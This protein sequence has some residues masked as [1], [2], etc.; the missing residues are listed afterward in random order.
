[1]RATSWWP[2]AGRSTAGRASSA[3]SGNF[4]QS[5]TFA[6][7]TGT[8]Q[9]GDGCATT[10]STF[11]GATSFYGFSTATTIGHSLVFPAGQTQ[12]VAHALALAG[13][14]GALVTIRSSS[15][16][17]AGNLALAI[18][19]TQTIDYV[20]VAD[21]HATVQPIGPGPPRPFTR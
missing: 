8:V 7:G 18:G 2:A 17:A 19:A 14:A 5:G 3:F 1:M 21:N 10:T 12:S 11:T 4:A 20:D 9:I 6:A 16:G 13:A 15:A